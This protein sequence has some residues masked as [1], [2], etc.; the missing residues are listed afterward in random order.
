MNMNQ[1]PRGSCGPPTAGMNASPTPN[2]A[3][4]GGCNPNQQRQPPTWIQCICFKGAISELCGHI[5][6]LVGICSADL[7][8]TTAQAIAT[9]MGCKL[10]GDIRHS[11]E[12]FMLA[13]LT[14]PTRPTPPPPATDGT[15]IPIDPVE[16]D[17]YMEEVKEY[18]KQH[19]RLTSHN[20]Q[21]Y[22]IFWGQSTESI[23][24][25]VE[26][27]PGFNEIRMD[28]NGI[29]LLNEI[30]LI[31]N[32]LECKV[33][34]ALSCRCSHSGMCSGVGAHAVVSDNIAL[35]RR[36]LTEKYP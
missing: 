34:L 26:A 4:L 17:I 14:C 10:G 8:T 15:V 3:Q 11:I 20:Q 21:L 13:T 18:M 33:V 35:A 1:N 36:G 30:H 29:C 2:Q 6:D 16:I 5:Y 27:C 19:R 23:H 22:T 28:S 25:K 32:E 31:T 24:V 9:Y 12:T 7:F